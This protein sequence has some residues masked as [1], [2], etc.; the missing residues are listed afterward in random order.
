MSEIKSST[1]Y[2]HTSYGATYYTSYV[3]L[4]NFISPLIFRGDKSRI[5]LASDGY[6]FR[7]RFEL[8]TGTKSSDDIDLATLD[9]PFANYNPLNKGWQPLTNG[10]N[11]ASQVLVGLDMED[12]NIRSYMA[13]LEIPVTFYFDREDD[14]RFAYDSLVFL[15]FKENYFYSSVGYKG[16][17]IKIPLNL[18]LSS[19]EF[20]PQFTEK[21]WLTQNRIFTIKATFSIRSV[22]LNTPSQTMIGSSYELD[23][24]NDSPDY[25]LT[26]EV[27]LEMLDHKDLMMSCIKVN[28]QLDE[29]GE[30]I[31]I[32]VADVDKT[33][34]FLKWN[35]PEKN[36]IS[37]ILYH[38]NQKG[39]PLDVNSLSYYLDN[40]NEDSSYTGYIE[41]HFN[42]GSY[43]RSYYG[44]KTKKALEKTKKKSINSLKGTS[45]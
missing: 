24:S 45:W 9:F 37:V 23:T 17:S 33:T 32:E 16:R 34:A 40:L 25:V 38:M 43:R 14:A 20:N 35:K 31:N 5:F 7:R 3:G 12:L 21:D 22:I 8:L 2:N 29:A 28:G 4:E 10:F 44:F 19:L 6:A 27:I 13:T 42:D 1:F 18:K 30:V 36:L 41:F 26:Q 15:G 39:Q 11:T